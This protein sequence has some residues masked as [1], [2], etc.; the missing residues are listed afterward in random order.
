MMKYMTPLLLANLFVRSLAQQVYTGPSEFTIGGS[1]P[2]DDYQAEPDVFDESCVVNTWNE[3]QR[4]GDKLGYDIVKSSQPVKG[5]FLTFDVL[6][7]DGVEKGDG[8]IP[9]MVWSEDDDS[10]LAD[11]AVSLPT[12]D[13][14]NYNNARIYGCVKRVLNLWEVAAV[15]QDSI[16]GKP[17]STVELSDG[18]EPF[19]VRS[20][21]EYNVDLI[22]TPDATS[23]VEVYTGVGAE[24]DDCSTG[25]LLVNDGTFII[26][27]TISNK[28]WPNGFPYDKEFKDIAGK[29]FPQYYGGRVGEAIVTLSDP[30]Y[31]PIFTADIENDDIDGTVEFCIRIAIKSESSGR[32]T[33]YI[34]SKKKIMVSLTAKIAT[35]AQAVG[36]EKIDTKEYEQT[37]LKKMDVVS[38]VCNNKNEQV[39]DGRSYS[40]GQN[41]RVCVSP[42]E[43]GIKEGYLVDGYTELSC[44]GVSLIANNVATD[45]LTTIESSAANNRLAVQSVLTPDLALGDSVNCEGKV[46]LSFITPQQGGRRMLAPSIEL[47]TF[48]GAGG[49]EESFEG[50]FKM[51]VKMNNIPSIESSASSSPLPSSSVAI[52]I[53]WGSV[54]SF[55]VSFLM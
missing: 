42:T 46:S 30:L 54:F 36:V 19:T 38:F 11:Y 49:G 15:G 29:N 14:I 8:V 6:V 35:F 20:F 26:T 44:G 43:A 53:G 21:F 39:Q 40:L 16:K 18:D 2:H 17:S 13:D 50:R 12:P 23:I 33:S 31:K 27:Q 22:Y 45:L 52:I 55:I 9:F 28:E 47:A 7:I 10:T 34:D 48:S 25:T 5:C 1:V 32:I 3:C 37:I 51:N 41:F 24:Q 4:N